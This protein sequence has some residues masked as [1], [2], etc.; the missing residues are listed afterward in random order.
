MKFFTKEKEKKENRAMKRKG[1]K[2]LGKNGKKLDTHT[3]LSI[4]NGNKSQNK[5]FSSS[6]R[7][8]FLPERYQQDKSRIFSEGGNSVHEELF[9]KIEG[10]VEWAGRGLKSMNERL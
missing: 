2:T 8:A 10:R 5:L 3:F 1:S 7:F 4:E 6:L 9:G